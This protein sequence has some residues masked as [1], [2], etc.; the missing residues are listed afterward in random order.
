MLLDSTVFLALDDGSGYECGEC[1]LEIDG[2]WRLDELRRIRPQARLQGITASF[3]L[4]YTLPRLP[5]YGIVRALACSSLN[6]HSLL[7]Y[8]AHLELLLT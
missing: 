5:S 7:V 8:S 1:V 2:I 6:A 3:S 4:S